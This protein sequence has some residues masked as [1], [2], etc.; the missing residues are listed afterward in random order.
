MQTLIKFLIYSFT[1]V[2]MLALVIGAGIIPLVA[3]AYFDYPDLE[4]LARILGC[5]ISIPMLRLSFFIFDITFD[6]VEGES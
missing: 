6:L 3:V 2:I 5:I 1:W 4:P